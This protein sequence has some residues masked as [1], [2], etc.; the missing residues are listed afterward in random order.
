MF[1]EYYSD[2]YLIA[3][4][5]PEWIKSGLSFNSTHTANFWQSS[6]DYIHAKI[7][8]WCA[9]KVTSC[10]KNKYPIQKIPLCKK[11]EPHQFIKIFNKNFR[12]IYL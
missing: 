9:K 11:N 5:N 12:I 7:I 4:T 3:I 6:A 8:L 10:A 2:Y 1:Q